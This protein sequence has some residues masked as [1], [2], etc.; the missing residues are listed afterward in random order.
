MFTNAYKAAC[1]NGFVGDVDQFI[2]ALRQSP[3]KEQTMDYGQTK[4]SSVSAQ[5]HAVNKVTPG[6]D[7]FIRLLASLF[8][9]EIFS[10]LQPVELDVPRPTMQGVEDMG[11]YQLHPELF[12]SEKNYEIPEKV[13]ASGQPETIQNYIT[14]KMIPAFLQ[15]LAEAI[16][17]HKGKGFD[18][19]REQ[20]KL[21]NRLNKLMSYQARPMSIIPTAIH[22]E[23]ELAIYKNYVAQQI[24]S[25][26][27]TL[28]KGLDLVNAAANGLADRQEA[29]RINEEKQAA[30]KFDK[31]KRT[32]TE[33]VLRDLVSNIGSVPADELALRLRGIAEEFAPAK[34]VDAFKQ[35]FKEV[36]DAAAPNRSDVKISLDPSDSRPLDKIVPSFQRQLMGSLRTMTPEDIARLVNSSIVP[37]DIRGWNPGNRG[38]TNLGGFLCRPSLHPMDGPMGQGMM[39]HHFA[40]RD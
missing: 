9:P 4:L 17:T 15:K 6:N 11:M 8:G 32:A 23:Y 5:E 40:N 16:E 3:K 35:G 1:A 27:L 39:S 14:L 2:T 10:S 26:N 7:S 18:L 13:V 36:M 30:A 33:E 37:E 24:C 19:L 20:R 34:P 38:Q 25:T 31:A 28:D 12:M 21:I 29:C 22:D